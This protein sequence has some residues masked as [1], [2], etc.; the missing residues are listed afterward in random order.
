MLVAHKE[1]RVLHINEIQKCHDMKDVSPMLCLEVKHLLL[2]LLI[3][4]MF[5]RAAFTVLSISEFHAEICCG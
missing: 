3:Q 1:Y 5:E 4:A 2:P